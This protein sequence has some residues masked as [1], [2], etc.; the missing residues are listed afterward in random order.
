MISSSS[1]LERYPSDQLASNAQYWLGES[2]FV[3]GQY[4]E[5]A[6]AFLKGIQTYAR[7][8]KAP[9][10]MLKLAM[11]LD[12]L[13]QRDAACTSFAELQ[14]RFPNAP[15][16]VRNRATSERQRIRCG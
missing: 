7:G 11:S 10:S 15:S 13:G 1:F 6:S 16:H 8:S 3:R 2:Y 9:D 14:S 12:R 4:K 5:A